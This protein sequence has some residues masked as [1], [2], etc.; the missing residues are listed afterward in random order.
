MSFTSAGVS[1]DVDVE[2]PSSKDP[3]G[4]PVVT[5]GRLAAALAKEL[6]SLDRNTDLEYNQKPGAVSLEAGVGVGAT[7]GQSDGGKPDAIMEAFIAALSAFNFFFCSFAASF[8]AYAINLARI[9]S[10]EAVIGSSVTS[11]VS[12]VI[13]TRLRFI[14]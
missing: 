4:A 10:S 3:T 13:L 8:W 2:S 5:P 14:H 7:R 12:I 6:K 9:K 11:S 1:V